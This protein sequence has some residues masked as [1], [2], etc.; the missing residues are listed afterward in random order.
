MKICGATSIYE[1]IASE[2]RLIGDAGF[3][4]IELQMDYPRALPEALLK[5]R[6]ELLDAL[7]CYA[8][9]R[10]AHLPCFV[11]LADVYPH[12]RKANLEY[13]KK[14]LD[15]AHAL[16]VG[17]INIHI[18]HFVPIARKT[19]GEL[20]GWGIAAAKQIA[21]HA[22]KNGQFITI[23]NNPFKLLTRVD[24]FRRVFE[25]VDAGFCLDIGHANMPDSDSAA[26][27]I[28]A[29]RKRLRHC[30]FHDNIGESDLHLPLG[31][32]R[33]EY[34]AIAKHLQRIGY[35]ET[36]TLEVFPDDREY[37]LISK[38]KLEEALG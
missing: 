22:A 5:R 11:N 13:A 31:A 25:E 37:L 14:A 1:D 27:F 2:I 20:M 9:V 26:D 34:K 38:R 8:L 24:E 6:R 33:I 15:V 12:A 10:V 32:G 35:K 23:E 29:F 30:H 36:I 7:S 19:K 3:G 28:N 21:K 17:K 18:G 16:E 4:G